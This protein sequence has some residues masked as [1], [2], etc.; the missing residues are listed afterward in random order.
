MTAVTPMKYAKSVCMDVSITAGMFPV[1]PITLAISLA[2]YGLV[3][4]IG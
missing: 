1:L 3:R 2:V 4:A